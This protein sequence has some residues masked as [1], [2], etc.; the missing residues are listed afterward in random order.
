V[1]ESVRGRIDAD[2]LCS[3]ES[4]RPPAYLR[5]GPGR[6]T[7]AWRSPD[8]LEAIVKRF[9]GMGGFEAWRSRLSGRVPLSPARR[10]FEALHELR[11]AGLP[12]PEPVA[13]HESERDPEL[14]LVVME[15][16]PHTDDLRQCLT[17]EPREAANYFDAVLA[18]TTKLHAAGWYHR[19]LYLD[20]FLVV[21]GGAAG[22][23]ALIDL[24]RARRG[25]SPRKRWFIKDLAA[26]WHS[27]PRGVPRTLALRFL[28]KWLN[29]RGISDR[30]TRHRT[31]RAILAK[32]RRMAAHV[33]RGGTSHPDAVDSSSG[34]AGESS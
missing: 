32:E 27:T 8:G 22:T 17:R 29:S 25:T 12:V 18:V 33:P 9:R 13:C 1:N 19:D 28:A 24:G 10:E 7:F 31:W 5:V 14:S 21:S 30:K 3:L 16:I 34:S 11:V 26:L 20:H 23:L 6:E 15:R 4:W 2:A